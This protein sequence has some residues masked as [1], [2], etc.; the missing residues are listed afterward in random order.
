GGSRIAANAAPR[1]PGIVRYALRFS[2][3]ILQSKYTHLPLFPVEE[4]PLRSPLS[5]SRL[6]RSR[7]CFSPLIYFYS[8]I[9]ITSSLFVITQIY[10][11]KRWCHHFQPEIGTKRQVY[12][13]R[14]LTVVL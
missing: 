13:V 7:I 1:L 12:I 9:F 5:I 8:K 3:P 2:T 10:L 4:S 6:F 14:S 11:F